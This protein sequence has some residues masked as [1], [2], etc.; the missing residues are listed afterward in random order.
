MGY[1]APKPLLAAVQVILHQG[2][3]GEKEGET[4]EGETVSGPFLLPRL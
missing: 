2:L 4:V 1:D 3:G